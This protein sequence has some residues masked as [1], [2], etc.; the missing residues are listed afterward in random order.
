MEIRLIASP[1][2]EML[3]SLVD[4]EDDILPPFHQRCAVVEMNGAGPCIIVLPRE[5]RCR[6]D[7]GTVSYKGLPTRAARE[8]DV[9]RIQNDDEVASGCVVVAAYRKKGRVICGIRDPEFC[10]PQGCQLFQVTVGGA[11]RLA[12]LVKAAAVS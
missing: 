3:D 8:H 1:T 11:L 6:A 2:R 7:I 12:D 10:L 4:L 9:R 5:G